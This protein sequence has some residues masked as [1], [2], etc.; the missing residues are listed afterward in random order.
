VVVNFRYTYFTHIEGARKCDIHYR[1]SCYERSWRLKNICQFCNGTTEEYERITQ[2]AEVSCVM[3]LRAETRNWEKRKR[4]TSTWTLRSNCLLEHTKTTKT[5]CLSQTNIQGRIT[6]SL[7]S[8]NVEQSPHVVRTLGV[9][10]LWQKRDMKGN[11][12]NKEKNF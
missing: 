1:L 12:K 3:W 9:A 11:A 10:E 6:K 4:R 5:D 8:V 2:T 7:K